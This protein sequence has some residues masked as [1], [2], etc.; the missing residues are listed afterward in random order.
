MS[1]SEKIVHAEDVTEGYDVIFTG[2]VKEF[3]NQLKE[4]MENAQENC[5]E[6]NMK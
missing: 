2:D 6:M 3:I 1:L 4:E 5:G